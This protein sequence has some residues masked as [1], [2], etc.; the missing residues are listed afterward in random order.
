MAMTNDMRLD[1]DRL[2]STVDENGF[3]RRAFV[4]AATEAL[5]ITWLALS[6]PEVADAAQHAHEATHAQGSSAVSFLSAA[7]LADV[8][9]IASQIIPSDGT[10]GAHEAGVVTFIDRALA[11]F[12][13]RMAETFRAQLSDF[14][15]LCR[16]QHPNSESFATLASKDQLS[17]LKSVEHTPFFGTMR[18]L[19]VLGMFS[20][21]SYGGNQG[22]AGWKLLGFEDQHAFA[23]PFGYYDRDY[24]GFGVEVTKSS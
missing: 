3:S 14:R 13:S 17:F 4:R 8:D 23:P 5:G 9:A 6:W 12:F 1:N 22:A 21:P 7:E 16:A 10:P 24:P 19:T 18:F 2:T 11:T 15:A 20:M